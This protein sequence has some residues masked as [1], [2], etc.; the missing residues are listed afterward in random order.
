[1]FHQIFFEDF[2]EY[3]AKK[4]EQMKGFDN[5]S[6]VL[7]KPGTRNEI[8]RHKG[9]EQMYSVL[10]GRGEVQVGDEKRDVG[11]GDAKFL[12]AD[13]PHGFMNNTDKLTILM[14][15]GAKVCP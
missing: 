12:P 4:P 14:M 2:P 11:V 8:H 13:I 3:D 15:I 7:I 5:F 9:V 6:R 1:M 10:R